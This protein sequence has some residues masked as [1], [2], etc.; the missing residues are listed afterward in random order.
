MKT[1]SKPLLRS[2]ALN[3]PVNRLDEYLE[4]VNRTLLEQTDNIDRDIS[5][6]AGRLKQTLT[7]IQV[8]QLKRTAIAQGV[9]DFYQFNRWV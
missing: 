2:T 1:T 6:V 4:Q 7:Q 9:W 3:T 8:Q 5:A